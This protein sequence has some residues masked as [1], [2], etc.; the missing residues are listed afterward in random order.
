MAPVAEEHSKVETRQDHN[1]LEEHRLERH[2][3]EACRLVLRRLWLRLICVFLNDALAHARL[4]LAVTSTIG[5]CN[6]DA[7]DIREAEDRANKDLHECV[8][9]R[10]DTLIAFLIRM[11]GKSRPRQ[12]DHIQSGKANNKDSGVRSEDL[13]VAKRQQCDNVEQN[14]ENNRDCQHDVAHSAS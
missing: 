7:P 10:V 3:E 5:R 9:S 6:S 1:E 8:H 4:F 2:F 14:E 13:N 12:I 11:T